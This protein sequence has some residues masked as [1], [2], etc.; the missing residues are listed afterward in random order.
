MVTVSPACGAIAALPSQNGDFKLWHQKKKIGIENKTSIEK[1]TIVI[2]TL[3][4]KRVVLALKQVLGNTESSY[5]ADF[6]SSSL[7]MCP[8]LCVSGSVPE[9]PS[10]GL[11]MRMECGSST[12][13]PSTEH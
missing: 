8:S 5:L 11:Y 13:A 2:E 9:L 7:L 10:S 3:V 1:G 6:S 12:G 4:L